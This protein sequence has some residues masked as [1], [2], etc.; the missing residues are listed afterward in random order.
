MQ[1]AALLLTLPLLP[2]QEKPSQDEIRELVEKLGS[3][4]IEE[5]ASASAKLLKLGRAALPELKKALG[6]KDKERVTRARALIDELGLDDLVVK[7]GGLKRA[8]TFERVDHPGVGPALRSSD[9]TDPFD[10]L[11]NYAEFSF[12]ASAGRKYRC[13]IYVGGCCGQTLQAWYQAT[14]LTVREPAG[15]GELVAVE[16]GGQVAL[17]V[18]T[19][20]RGLDRA[21]G[22][23]CMDGKPSRWGWLELN[24]PEYGT[25][26][27]KKVRL[28]TNRKGFAVAGAVVSATRKKPPAALR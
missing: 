27:L 17:P 3:D 13:W 14:D 4:S 20:I 23:S 15:K 12:K 8:G 9:Y 16:P 1:I 19:L 22:G 11:L 10:T 25:A 26:G 5:R 6:E 28:L 2:M 21:C 24:L 7:A 18:K